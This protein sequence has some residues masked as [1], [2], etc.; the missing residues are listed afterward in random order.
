MK[1]TFF[2]NPHIDPNFKAELE[3]SFI[4]SYSTSSISYL[5]YLLPLGLALSILILT[6][7]YPKNLKLP[8]HPLKPATNSIQISKLN[9]LATLESELDLIETSLLSDADINAAI[10]FDNID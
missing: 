6:L 1:K 3:A 7:T 8:K 4:K 2:D 5:N 9:D 10:N